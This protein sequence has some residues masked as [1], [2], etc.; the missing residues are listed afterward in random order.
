M[1][2]DNFL[3]FINESY[4]DVSKDELIKFIE[5]QGFTLSDTRNV[6]TYSFFNGDHDEFEGL[7]IYTFIGRVVFFYESQDK[8]W[9]VSYNK[10]KTYFDK[11]TANSHQCSFNQ[12]K[13]QFLKLQ[14]I[15][16][17]YKMIFEFCKIV[18]IKIKDESD[19]EIEYS[20][21]ISRG[22][23]GIKVQFGKS[24]DD[25]LICI[26]FYQKG[27]TTEDFDCFLVNEGYAVKINEV[28]ADMV[29]QTT[30]DVRWK[31]QI[32]KKLY[33]YLESIE[34][35]D[36]AMQLEKIKIEVPE[37]LEKY[38]GLIKMKKFGF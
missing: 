9:H 33:Q 19:F 21:S 12:F 26:D 35:L 11:P 36:I 15:A 6:Y 4:S 32:P 2:I 34:D 31:F 27:S 16:L 14:E 1:H 8:T 30:G 38:R 7:V 29:F 22:F 17:Y 28:F 3:T 23:R 25:P 10:K 13:E 5:H 20:N 18:D 37:M 24:L